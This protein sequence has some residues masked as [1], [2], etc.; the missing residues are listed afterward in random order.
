MIAGAISPL[1]RFPET[2]PGAAA[3]SENFQPDEMKR[4]HPS[5][6]ASKSYYCL[7]P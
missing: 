7:M 1:E 5:P 4:T 3:C 2:R 6:S